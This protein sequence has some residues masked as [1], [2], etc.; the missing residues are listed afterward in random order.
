VVGLS[1]SAQLLGVHVSYI[2]DVCQGGGL[3]Y[4]RLGGKRKIH[5]K[6]EWLEEWLERHAQELDVQEP[7]Q[8]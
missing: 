4:A 3:R 6:R 1:P 7:Q 2:Y 5:I 8:V